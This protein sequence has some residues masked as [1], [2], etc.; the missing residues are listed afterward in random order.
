MTEP[1]ILA[2]HSDP[3]DWGINYSI[4]PESYRYREPNV[5][6]IGD[7]GESPLAVSLY[8]GFLRSTRTISSQCFE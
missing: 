1:S 4:L 2:P 3:T 8:N 6:C 7:L 5:E